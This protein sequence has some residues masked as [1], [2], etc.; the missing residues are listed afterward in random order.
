MSELLTQRPP[1]PS[2]RFEVV[3]YMRQQS[4]AYPL[5][6]GGV[7]DIGRSADC[8]IQIDDPS[9]S[10]RHARLHVGTGVEIEDLDSANGTSLMRGGKAKGDVEETD[11]SA[12]QRL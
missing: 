2:S 7:I 3:V 11:S 12:N 1:A 6:P 9:V 10:R 5:A 4:K 8:P